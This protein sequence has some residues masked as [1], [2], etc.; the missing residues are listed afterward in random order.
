[1][2]IDH[3]IPKAAGGTDDETNLWLACPRCNIYKDIHTHAMDSALQ[4]LVRLFN[5]RTQRWDEHFVYD[6]DRATII[7]KTPIGRATVETLKMN[8]TLSVELRRELVALGV[9]PPTTNSV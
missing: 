4:E 5:P 3:I 6:R 7:G 8:L 2:H 9:Y 1:M